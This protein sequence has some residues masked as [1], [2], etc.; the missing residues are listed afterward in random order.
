MVVPYGDPNPVHQRKNAFDAGEYNIGVLAN[1]LE[2]GCDCV[3]EIRYFDAVLANGQG[4]PYTLRNAVCLHEEDYGVLWR[5]YNFRT[6]KTEVRRSRRLV[7][8]SFSTVANYDYGFFWY[9]Y[10]D[11]TIQFEGK[12]TGIVSTG[13]VAPGAK[14]SHGQL[15]NPDGLYAPIHLHFFSFRLDFD[16]DG[17]P[18]HGLRS[19]HR[20]RPGRRRQPTQRRL[21]AKGDAAAP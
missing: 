17:T 12:L 21:R 15:L 10:Q 18:E 16:V 8:S 3:G 6:E 1:S 19:P 13:A 5:H 14:P 20:A 9:F 4:K 2:L 11:G 7:V